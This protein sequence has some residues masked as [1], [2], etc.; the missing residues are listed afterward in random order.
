ML[1]PGEY[2][3]VAA[4]QFTLPGWP[5]RYVVNGS[6]VDKKDSAYWT[7]G[8]QYATETVAA[9]EIM[10]GAWTSGTQTPSE[11][12][13]TVVN[14]TYYDANDSSCTS[15]KHELTD[16]ALTFTV[17]TLKSA[18]AHL[19]QV[20]LGE[21]EIRTVTPGTDGTYT[22]TGVN[23]DVTITVISIKK[24]DVNLDSYVDSTDASKVLYYAT[25]R[26]ILNDLQ[27]IAVDVNH[28]GYC[29]SSDALQILY[30]ATMKIT[31]F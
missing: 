7:D 5:V 24:G 14:K 8:A 29:D 3:A 30:Y 1:Q 19:V 15:V 18:Y 17:Q 11:H 2:R 13:V 25:G 10:C 4:T 6:N 16:G 23:D 31:E 27:L 12:S 21:G 9:G 28:D 22:V 20:Q 26:E